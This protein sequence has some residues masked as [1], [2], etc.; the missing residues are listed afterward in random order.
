M[1]EPEL[2]REPEQCAPNYRKLAGGQHSEAAQQSGILDAGR[3]RGERRPAMGVS[4]HA[5]RTHTPV[6]EE[7]SLQQTPSAILWLD[8]KRGGRSLPLESQGESDARLCTNVV[9]CK[10]PSKR[11][12]TIKFRCREISSLCR[13]CFRRNSPGATY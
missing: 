13:K 7:S 5:V 10:F 2:V 9:R 11:K 8:H 3:V 12:I 6:C 4:P 1:P